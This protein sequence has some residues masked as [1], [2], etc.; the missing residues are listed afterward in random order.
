[1]VKPNT[2]DEPGFTDN[3]LG[4]A[5]QIADL[6]KKDAGSLR[7]AWRRHYRTPPPRGFSRDLLMRAIAYKIQERAFGGHTKSTLRRLATIA[8]T[9]QA[10]AGQSL[11]AYPSLKSGTRLVREWGGATHTVLVLDDGF[12]YA[13]QRYA[14]LTKIATTISGLHRSGPLFFGLKRA[15]PGFGGRP[16]GSKREGIVDG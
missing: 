4:I 7:E 6:A 9:L 14:S 2:I 16:R 11:Y 1:M 3:R 10:S 12:E 15:P 8:R 13:G 5:N